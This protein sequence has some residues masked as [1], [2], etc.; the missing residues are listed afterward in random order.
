M[1]SG[2][3]LLMYDSSRKLTIYHFGCSGVSVAV[4]QSV[5]VSRMCQA[6]RRA[7][8]DVAWPRIFAELLGLPSAR[9]ILCAQWMFV[10]FLT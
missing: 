2:Q 9:H 5:A 8:A 7:T 3:N 1:R 10:E 6:P 4:G